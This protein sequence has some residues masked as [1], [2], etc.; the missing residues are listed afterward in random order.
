ML[1]KLGRLLFSF[2]GR[3]PRSTFWWTALLLA[4]TFV[5]L[6]IFLETMFG[7]QSSLVLY[8]PFFWALAALATKRLRDR[9]R[10]PAWLLVLLIPVLGPLWLIF[11]LCFRR[12]TPGENQYGQ[13]PLEIGVDYLTVKY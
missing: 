7:R 9:G 8:P 4:F 6:L 1:G 3:I 11:E 10:H 12:G 2:G 13:D 5:V